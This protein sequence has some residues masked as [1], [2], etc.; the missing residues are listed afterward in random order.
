M[1]A[2][3]ADAVCDLLFADKWQGLATVI[4]GLCIAFVFTFHRIPFRALIMALGH[5]KTYAISTTTALVLRV[6]FVV[7][8]FQIAG[9]FGV[10]FGLGISSIL[11]NMVFAHILNRVIALPYVDQAWL[12]CRFMLACVP[13]VAFRIVTVPLFEELGGIALLLAT[14]VSAGACL[15]IFLAC[16]FTVWAMTGRKAGFESHLAEI[17]GIAVTRNMSRLKRKAA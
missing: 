4:Q 3:H 11:M 2:L 8:G 13:M 10:I 14:A 12:F 15:V 6:L 7:T 1:L 16:T 5:S 9:I 17:G